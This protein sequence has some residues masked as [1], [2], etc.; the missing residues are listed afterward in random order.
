M[1]K[2]AKIMFENK[3]AVNFKVEYE[4]RE[5]IQVW[6]VTVDEL[7]I[8]NGKQRNGQQIK[9]IPVLFSQN[10]RNFPKSLGNKILKKLYEWEITVIWKISP[11]SD[12]FD[13]NFWKRSRF[14]IS[15]GDFDGATVG[16]LWL[17]SVGVVY[18]DIQKFVDKIPF[19]RLACKLKYT[20]GDTLLTLIANWLTDRIQRVGI[21]TPILG[22][23]MG[24]GRGPEGSNLGCQLFIHNI[25]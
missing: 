4:Q 9:Q 22:W 23:W 14:T 21:N 18:Q 12:T 13:M 17:K 11:V 16:K 6:M 5:I 10:T 24:T 20:F 1:I 15:T 3:L 19:E 2:I 7:I 25:Y 8:H